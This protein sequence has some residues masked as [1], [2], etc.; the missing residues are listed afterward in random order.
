[1]VNKHKSISYKA[2]ITKFLLACMFIA[3]VFVPLGRMFGNM[4]FSSVRKVF[5]APTFPKLLSNSLTAAALSTA[6]TVF[7]AYLLAQRIERTAMRCKG[8][9]RTL[10]VLPMLIPSI[11]HGM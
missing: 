1:M 10:F 2:D 5:T 8:L 11:S 9:F 6:I 7:L 3:L 4:T